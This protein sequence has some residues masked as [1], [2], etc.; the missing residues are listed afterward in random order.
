MRRKRIRADEDASP[1]NPKKARSD[2]ETHITEVVKFNHIV[3]QK[4]W[5][6]FTIN[7]EDDLLARLPPGYSTRLASR[8]KYDEGKP[9]SYILSTIVLTKAETKTTLSIDNST[10]P[11]E[12]NGT[13]GETSAM[14]DKV[15]GTGEVPLEQ[16]LKA[17]TIAAGLGVTSAST[18][19]DVFPLAKAIQRLFRAQMHEM[20]AESSSL[21]TKLYETIDAGEVIWQNELS[22]RVAIV[23]CDSDIVDKMIPN[24]EDFTE[25][26]ALQHIRQHAP[27]IPVPEPLGAMRSEKTAYIFMAFIRGPTLEIVWS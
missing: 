7:P 23:K 21:W 9:T 14:D 19:I 6:A 13:S 26:T 20:S 11:V 22:R 4:I 1:H 3:L 25:Y 10:L 17:E 8:S 15:C 16:D 18:A 27:D 12:P 24:C 5:K 2:L